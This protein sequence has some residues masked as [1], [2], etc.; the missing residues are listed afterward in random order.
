MDPKV[1]APAIKIISSIHTKDWPVETR[2]EKILESFQL[3]MWTEIMPD[4]SKY[5][6][7]VISNTADTHDYKI[8]KRQK[9]E[10]TFDTEERL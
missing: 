3:D 7:A 5:L 9:V 8:L 4:K 10:E 1:C 2:R 6:W